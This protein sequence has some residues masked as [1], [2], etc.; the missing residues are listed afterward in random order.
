MQFIRL[1]KSI[2]IYFNCNNLKFSDRQ[3]G[4]FLEKQSDQGLHCLLIHLH[5]LEVHVSRHGRSS[6][7]NVF[8]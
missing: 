4:Q 1:G 8:I 7:Q 2:M 5:H 3:V 6:P